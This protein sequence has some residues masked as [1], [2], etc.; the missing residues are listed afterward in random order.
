MKTRIYISAE[1]AKVGDQ[2]WN[3]NSGEWI[4]WHGVAKIHDVSPIIWSREIDLGWV[5]VGERL[6]ESYI[7]VD[8]ISEGKKSKAYHIKN[9]YSA[10]DDLITNVTHWLDTSG[11]PLP[12]VDEAEEAWEKWSKGM[13]FAEGAQVEMREAFKAAWKLSREGR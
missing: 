13:G 9:W 10:E 12:V 1:E 5:P 6:P 7:T 4:E 8:V 2:W 11:I 3:K